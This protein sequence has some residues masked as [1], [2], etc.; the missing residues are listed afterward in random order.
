VSQHF[1]GLR[2]GR[3]R[4]DRCIPRSA[5]SWARWLARFDRRGLS[6][7]ISERSELVPYALITV[8]DPDD[9]QLEVTWS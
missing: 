4:L 8:R 5:G 2:I 1:G 9:I 6:L 3:S 7:G